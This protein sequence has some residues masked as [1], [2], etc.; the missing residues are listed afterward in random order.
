[1]QKAVG[2]GQ[3][4]FAYCLLHTANFFILMTNIL[5]KLQTFTGSFWGWII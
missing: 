3:Y 2:N 4:F 5:Y 1:M